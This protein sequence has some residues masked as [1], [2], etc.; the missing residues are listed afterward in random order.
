MC[1]IDCEAA[2]SKNLLLPE[3][4]W[5]APP[6]SLQKEKAKFALARA[7]ARPT[8]CGKG[9]VSMIEEGG[10]GGRGHSAS[11]VSPPP[12]ASRSFVRRRRAPFVIRRK[13]DN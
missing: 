10:E 3:E 1:C 2:R 9:E 12:A 11:V 7:S 8:K 4:G 5:R 6:I 13:K